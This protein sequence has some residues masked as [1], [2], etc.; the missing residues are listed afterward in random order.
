MN[1][2]LIEDIV[3]KALKFATN[4]HA[5]QYRKYTG[6]PYVNHPIAVCNLV[7]DFTDDKDILAAALLHDTMEDCEVTYEDINSEFGKRVADMVKELTNDKEEISKKGKVD[8]MVNK[9]NKMSEPC[10][11]IKMCDILNNMSS[12]INVKQAT[13]YKKILDKTKNLVDYYKP[14]IYSIDA[15]YKMKFGNV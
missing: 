4:A 1:I 10:F 6:E 3:E 9:L 13:T 14:W 8:Y 15:V 2:M 5:G 7:S 12:T 11:L